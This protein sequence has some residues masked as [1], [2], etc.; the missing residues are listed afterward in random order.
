MS[1]RIVKIENGIVTQ[2][3][4]LGLEKES[5]TAQESTQQLG[6]SGQWID[7]KNSQGREYAVGDFW[8]ETA[9]D[10]I[11]AT[12][13]L[14]WIWSSETQEYVPPFPAPGDNFDWN[15]ELQVWDPVV[16][17]I[18]IN[19]ATE[20]E[21]QALDGVGPVIAGAIVL[22]RNTNGLFTSLLN[23]SVRVDGVSAAM[24]DGWTNVYVGEAV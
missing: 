21:L 18:N 15:E 16:T 5:L 22:E 20:T 6:L 3:I 2:R 23:L 14:G 19:S 17:Q 10:Y 4:V 12:P 1:S 11:P 7:A 13:F 9:Q 8:D 24:A